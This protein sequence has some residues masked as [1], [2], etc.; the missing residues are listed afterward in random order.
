MIL[1]IIGSI[2]L[3]C[4]ILV[5]YFGIKRGI[6]NAILWSLFPILHGFHEFAEY[7][8]NE[9]NAPFIVERFELIFAFGSSFALLAAS[10]EFTGGFLKPSGK[11]AGLSGFLII[12]YIVLIIP[13]VTLEEI[14]DLNW[15]VGLLLITFWR[16][17]FGF[18]LVIISAASIIASYFA[19]KRKKV[20]ISSK[21]KITTSISAILLCIFSVFEGFKSD[22]VIFIG[23]R[24]FTL[25]FSVL[26]PVLVVFSSKLGI[27]HILIINKGGTLLHG[28]SFNEDRNIFSMESEKDQHEAILSAGFIAAITGYSSEILKGG[29][30][31]TIRSENVYLVM[32]KKNDL[33]YTLQ[34]INTNKNLRQ[35]ISNFMEQIHEEVKDKTSIHEVDDQKIDIAI[36]KNFATYY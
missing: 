18:I 27:Q 17:L 8:L 5:G 6:P 24:G 35:S 33:I 12:T 3:V 20:S 14:H 29:E 15:P 11:I 22:N 26:V 30:S 4:G 13:E 2:M 19:L 28:F 10:I 23:L 25:S 21:M 32:V 16:F 34:S 9:F 7:F 36:R 1:L 31:T